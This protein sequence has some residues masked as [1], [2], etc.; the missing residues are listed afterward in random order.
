MTTLN[1]TGPVRL[2][3]WDDLRDKG[4]KD[5]KP[6]IY[7]K[8][9]AGFPKPIYY[10]KSPTWLEHEIDAYILSLIAKRDASATEAA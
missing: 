6:T 4:I 3:G 5:S 2:L 7:R 9:K 10:G 1:S 8:M